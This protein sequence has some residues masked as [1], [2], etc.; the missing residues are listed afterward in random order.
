MTSRFW[1]GDALPAKHL[2]GIHLGESNRSAAPRAHSVGGNGCTGGINF[3]EQSFDFIFSDV[4]TESLEVIF[5]N[6]WGKICEGCAKRT[7]L[8]TKSR[9]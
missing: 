7:A 1:V 3:V 4:I 6:Q 2:C 5:K 9:N 8:T